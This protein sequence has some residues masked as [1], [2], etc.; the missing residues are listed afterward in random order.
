MLI[1]EMECHQ[2][3]S[4]FKGFLSSKFLS[5][6]QYSLATDSGNGI[7]KFRPANFGAFS[8]TLGKTEQNRTIH[9]TTQLK[10]SRN[11]NIFG[12]CT[13]TF[14]VHCLDH[15]KVGFGGAYKDENLKLFPIFPFKKHLLQFLS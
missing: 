4:F 9:A 11:L 15:N 3:G 12:Y 8:L 5:N 10:Q 13:F 14:L 1:C 2:T 6:A 7:G